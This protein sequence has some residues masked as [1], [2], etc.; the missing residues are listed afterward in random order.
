[1]FHKKSVSELNKF[2]NVSIQYLPTGDSLHA[3]KIKG[4]KKTGIR[5]ISLLNEK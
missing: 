1:M 4:S 3:L 5:M 2:E